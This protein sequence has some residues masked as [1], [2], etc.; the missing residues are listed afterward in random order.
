[1]LDRWTKYQNVEILGPAPAPLN[2]VRGRFRNR[3]LIRSEKN[4][5]LQNIV[6]QWIDLIKK[7][8]IVRISIDVDPYNFL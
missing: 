8:Q 2:Y 6:R 5:N 3:F 7:P 1:M 4:V